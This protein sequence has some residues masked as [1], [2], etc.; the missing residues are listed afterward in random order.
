MQV[1]AVKAIEYMYSTVY[2]QSCRSGNRVAETAD[3]RSYYRKMYFP[4]VFSRGIIFF[5][6]VPEPIQSDESRYILWFKAQI[7]WHLEKQKAPDYVNK[8]ATYT[9]ITRVWVF[10]SLMYFLIKINSPC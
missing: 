2:I 5:S 9:P 6:R 8:G 3:V 7:I 10:V 1:P 4:L